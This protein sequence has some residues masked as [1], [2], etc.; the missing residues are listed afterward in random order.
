MSDLN[1]VAKRIHN[2]SPDPVRLTLA[3]GDEAVYRFEG[4][5]FF[6]QEFQ[7]EGERVDSDEDATYRLITSEDGESV[8][9]GR[10]APG[11]EGWSLVGEV[12]AAEAA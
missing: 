9:L 2:V 1:P 3:G 11:E 7:G 5:E 12:E 10:Q 6:Q 8:L 4:T